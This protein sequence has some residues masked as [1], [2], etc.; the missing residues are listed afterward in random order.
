MALNL[1][2]EENPPRPATWRGQSLASYAVSNSEEAAQAYYSP[3][4]PN[5]ED[6]V[7]SKRS[8]SR[9]RNAI[10]AALVA[11]L[12]AGLGTGGWF[13]HSQRALASE[14]ESAWS[15]YE[16]TAQQYHDA[17]VNAN[18][19]AEQCR[20]TTHDEDTC[21]R[22]DDAILSAEKVFPTLTKGKADRKAIDDTK[23]A[24][25][26]GRDAIAQLSAASETIEEEIRV[27]AAEDLRAALVEAR[28]VRAEISDI[29][30]WKLDAGSDSS[31]EEDEASD[32]ASAGSDTIAEFTG[33][34]ARLDRYIDQASELLVDGAS[35]GVPQVSQPE[36]EYDENGQPVESDARPVVHS[37]ADS[38]K[39]A[40]LTEDASLAD[41]RDLARILA[42]L[43][44]SIR[45]EGEE[46]RSVRSS[47]LSE[48][49]A[50]EEARKKA[51]EE[52]A[53]EAERLEREARESA[54]S[55]Q[56]TTRRRDTG[57]TPAD[58]QA[59]T[60]Q[61]DAGQPEDTQGGGDIPAADGG[62][63][64]DTDSQADEGTR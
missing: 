13:W 41:A 64:T 11:F 7:R 43:A 56:D 51:R 52:E 35:I 54:A 36:P 57:Y 55:Q 29:L 21:D 61:Q 38:G 2:A 59:D 28:A 49:S 20:V 32:A 17:L 6:A 5:P 62:T 18:A 48:R 27:G 8:R 16:T 9:R 12:V 10:A 44:V 4:R 33:E 53:A 14:Y 58:S 60:S 40:S 45:T 15:E 3:A 34:V 19:L 24:T 37:D 63:D 46:L 39:P 42:D 22:L 31:E 23:A 1:G 47:F 26:A 30:E 50:R 25:K